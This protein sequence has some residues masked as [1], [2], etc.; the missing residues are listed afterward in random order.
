MEP[1][2]P[3]THKWLDLVRPAVTRAAERYNHQ[4]PEAFYSLPPDDYARRL[5]QENILLQLEH[6]RSYDIVTQREG[7]G[8][9]H[10]L[11]WYYDIGSGTLSNWNVVNQEFV[12]IR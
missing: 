4:N 6:L 1:Q 2:I 8:Q 9:L 12:P 3:H 10:L 7:A 5:E 11:G